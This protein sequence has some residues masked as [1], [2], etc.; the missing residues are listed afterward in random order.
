MRG[1]SSPIL[2]L[3]LLIGGATAQGLPGGATALNETHGDW[4]LACV[5]AE[6]VARCAITQTQVSM[7]NRQRILAVELTATEGGNTAHG[8]LVLPF[9]L[10]LESGVRLTIDEAAPL[11]P[12]RFSTCL[13][14]GC[15]VPFAFD[16]QTTS[17]LK[18]GTAISVTATA[19]D[20][21]QEVAFS[22]SLSGFISA[23]AR[24]TELGG[25]A[26]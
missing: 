1:I 9:G 20:S 14:A 3:A 7:E 25:P 12:L 17:A 10:R 5:A 11:A 24:L 16:G 13:P 8:M 18:A 19:D 4:T 22:I 15:L 2:A 23:L 26:E 6:G 21:G